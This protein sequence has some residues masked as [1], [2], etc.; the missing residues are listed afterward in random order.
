M[1]EYF[2]SALLEHLLCLWIMAVAFDV[3]I[4]LVSFYKDQKTLKWKFKITWNLVVIL[5]V[6]I[7]M[8]GYQTILVAKD[9]SEESYL[10]VEGELVAYATRRNTFGSVRTDDEKFKVKTMFTLYPFH[11]RQWTLPRTLTHGTVYYSEHSNLLLYFEPD[12]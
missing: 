11:T 4:V 1:I 3:F 10:C 6:T 5:A 7:G 2:K 12:E 8:T 9:I